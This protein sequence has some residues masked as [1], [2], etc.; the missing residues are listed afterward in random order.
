MKRHPKDWSG[1]E[2]S[3][4]KLKAPRAYRFELIKRREVPALVAAVKAWFPEISVGAAS[5]Y[6]DEKFYDDDVYFSGTTGRNVLVI[7]I[8]RSNEL[9]G[10]F[11]CDRDR[12]TLALYAR[13]GVIAPAHR[14]RHL[15]HAFPLLAEAVARASGME[16][17]YAMATLKVPHV[18][19]IFEKL[20]WRLIGITPG[21]D[22]EMV[23]PGVVK[24][25]YEAVYAQVLVA[26]AS[27]LRPE[28]RNLTARTRAFFRLLY[29]RENLRRT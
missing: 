10:L 14:G 3:I 27:L 25:V 20:G 22:R 24:R 5:C 6:L 4:T 26:N 29:P 28:A 8:K 21:Y 19:Q 17:I 11:S 9:A 16:M 12:N 18:Q 15:A 7:L 2:E 1:I 13:L 23:A